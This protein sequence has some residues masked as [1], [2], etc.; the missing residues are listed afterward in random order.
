MA[1]DHG[2]GVAVGTFVSFTRE[3]QSSYGHWYHGK[4]R[5]GWL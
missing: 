1:L 3:D 2:Y 4:L 5:T